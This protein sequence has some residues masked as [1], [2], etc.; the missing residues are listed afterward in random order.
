MFL[1]ASLIVSRLFSKHTK[2]YKNNFGSLC[3][4]ATEDRNGQNERN[5]INIFIMSVNILSN[6][7]IITFVLMFL[8]I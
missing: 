6:V 5:A 4:E 3:L 1:F 8:F 2:N 7:K